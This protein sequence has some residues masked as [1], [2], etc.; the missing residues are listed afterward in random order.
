MAALSLFRIPLV[1]PQPSFVLSL[2]SRLV[3]IAGEYIYDKYSEDALPSQAAKVNAEI[4]EAASDLVAL[5]LRL[6]YHHGNTDSSANASFYKSKMYAAI[7]FSPPEAVSTDIIRRCIDYTFVSLSGD[8]NIAVYVAKALETSMR[9]GDVSN[10]NSILKSCSDDHNAEKKSCF[11]A[12]N[13][14]S[15]ADFRRVPTVDTEMHE[16]SY[17]PSWG[18]AAG[19]RSSLDSPWQMR[20]YTP[21]GQIDRTKLTAIKRGGRK[22]GSRRARTADESSSQDSPAMEWG[23]ASKSLLS[24]TPADMQQ[25]PFP[26]DNDCTV[27]NNWRVS[28]NA[29][30]GPHTSPMTGASKNSQLG[31]QTPVEIGLYNENGVRIHRF[32][33]RRHRT[34]LNRRGKKGH[35]TSLKHCSDSDESEESVPARRHAYQD[36]ERN[37]EKSSDDDF[38]NINNTDHVPCIKP[39]AFDRRK[40]HFPCQKGSIVAT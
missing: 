18:E 32:G 11:R 38:A 23:L 5:G 22:P 27:N 29:M 25:L 9:S 40:Q 37:D 24:P 2:I 20:S 8:A 6:V 21:T 33:A 1:E 35:D 3:L 30:D 36:I 39:P 31:P 16:Q 10:A 34:L 26:S 19:V 15:A 4:I 12:T 13:E 7:G 14:I 17:E 28:S